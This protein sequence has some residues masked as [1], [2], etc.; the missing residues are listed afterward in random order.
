MNL[1]DKKLKLISEGFT[2]SWVFSLNEGQVNLMYNRLVESKYGDK[3][4]CGC[5]KGT[6]KCGPECKKC[7]CGKQKQ[8]TKEAQITYDPKVPGDI[9]KA[10][11]KGINLSA[12][13]KVTTSLEE[14][15]V[16]Q[17]QQEFF[18]VVRA[19]QKGD[20]PK[21]GKAGKAAKEMTKKDVKDFASTKH[22]GLPKKVKKEE[23]NEAEYLDMIGKAFNKNLQNKISD[24][25]PQGSI[26]SLEESLSRIIEKNLHPR[27]TKED[28][29]KTLSRLVNESPQIAEPDVKPD[30]KPGIDTPTKPEIHP[31]DDPLRPGRRTI[32]RPAPQAEKSDLPTWL[33]WNS[34]SNKK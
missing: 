8:E 20:I 17:K 25:R 2:P 32:P 26:D 29:V 22:K 7:D 19:M 11:Q 1:N 13:G 30:V 14:K 27:I 15:A 24:V 34:I 10:K 16:S 3:C 31:Q 9:E 12:D 28:L 5:E 21:K 18:G 23:T 4:A 33:Q 6:C